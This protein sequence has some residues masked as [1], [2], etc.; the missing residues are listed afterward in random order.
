MS[1]TSEYGQTFY[2][3]INQHC[4]KEVSACSMLWSANHAIYQDTES[5]LGGRQTETSVFSIQHKRFSTVISELTGGYNVVYN[6]AFLLGVE[7]LIA[8]NLCNI[9]RTD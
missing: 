8:T 9:H 7:N 1:H 4:Y 3:Q 6:I 5:K 2:F